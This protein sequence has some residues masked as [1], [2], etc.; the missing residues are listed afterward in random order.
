MMG[1]PWKLCLAIGVL[2]STAVG[3]PLAAQTVYT[4]TD[5]GGTVHFADHAPADAGNVEERNLPARQPITG[6][7]DADVAAKAAADGTATPGAAGPAK[8][9]V[10]SSK[11]DHSG[12]T[13]MHVSG[14]VKNAGGAAATGVAVVVSSLDPGQGNPCFHSEVSVSPSTLQGGETGTFE[15]D[16]DSPC[17][18][19]GTTLDLT[20]LGQ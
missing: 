3:S 12:P 4:W 17:L 8:L 6:G 19:E 15:S 14:I 9:L 18:Q 5:K 20:T 10:V 11:S 1:R 2:A 7:E 13:S 16:I